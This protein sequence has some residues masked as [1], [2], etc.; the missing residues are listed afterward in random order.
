MNR[1]P[2]NLSLRDFG[3]HQ[4]R[5]PGSEKSVV[6]VHG[7]LS[8]G[9][10]AWGQPSWP[11]LLAK[12]AELQDVGVF[13][14]SYQTT[15]SSRT[16]SIGD[17]VDALREHFNLDG[18]WDQ[19]RLVFVCHSMGGIVARRFIVVNQAK[20]IE[21]NCAI[22]LFLV[23][24]PSLGSSDAN[25]IE[26][27]ALV[28]Q[29]TQALALRFSQS[30]T[31]LN[32]LDRE[33]MAL[34]ESGR[35][36]ITGKELVEDRAVVLKRWLGLRKQVV[37]PFSSGRYF[38]EAF[39]V[40]ASDHISISKPQASDAIQHRIL[41]RFITEFAYPVAD[42]GLVP[43][44][45]HETAQAYNAIGELRGKL[46][47]IVNRRNAL[48]AVHEAVL[49]TLHYVEH[50]RG[51]GSR[52]AQ[53]EERLSRT[54]SEVRH[55]VQPY[56]PDLA[57]L[58]WVKGHGWADE[59]LWKDT[60]FKDIVSQLNEILERLITMVQVKEALLE[61][62]DQITRGNITI[63][64]GLKR[65]LFVSFNSA[66]RQWASWIAWTLEHAGYSVSFQ[67]WDL[68][69][70]LVE[71]MNMALAQSSLTLAVVSDRYFQ[72]GFT[73]TEWAARFA[74]D[75][76]GKVGRVIPVK[77]EP[78]EDEHIF[79][80][81][82]FIDL[83]GCNQVEAR[84]R[85]LEN[86]KPALKSGD[87]SKSMTRPRFPGRPTQPTR[88]LPHPAF[89]AG[90]KDLGLNSHA[91][92]SN[93]VILVHGIRT[94]ALWLHS[95]IKPVLEEH[96]FKVQIINY[97]L[98]D[99]ICFLMPA[100]WIRR[101]AIR[102]SYDQ[103]RLV[104]LEQHPAGQPSIIAHSFGTV[105][106]SDI[107]M[108]E[109]D[110]RADRVIFCGSIV[111]YN[112][113]VEQITARLRSSLLN[114]VGTRDYWPILTESVT[115]GYGS[116]GAYGFR[117][118]AV[119][120]RWHD[121][122]SHST[123]LSKEF[124]REFWV[125]FLQDGTV[126]APERVERT[127]Q[128]ISLLSA[129]KLKYVALVAA[130]GAF[131]LWPRGMDVMGSVYEDVV[132]SIAPRCCMVSGHIHNMA[133]NPIVGAEVIAMS[134]KG[135]ML[136]RDLTDTKGKYHLEVEKGEAIRIFYLVGSAKFAES[137]I[138]PIESDEQRPTIMFNVG[139]VAE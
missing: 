13:V 132:S 124:C 98:L 61:G 106:V 104:L 117:R 69:G 35:P 22:G 8:G 50:R 112:F 44:S 51:G 66:D 129:F 71:H 138:L 65:G 133:G 7:I 82:A 36:A 24:S 114:E 90:E 126:T 78:M 5:K 89:P 63:A 68:R 103:I 6:F 77:I 67:D 27:L 1:S 92:G 72:S 45:E 41:K 37:E 15:L 34:K 55:A 102:K 32:D 60:R 80:S 121:G 53:V 9:E 111:R 26:Q 97:G 131:L 107:L 14:F 79:G 110:F 118:P 93:L 29:H 33:F 52:D 115:W 136:D 127:P 56:D 21:H 28:L 23:A 120:D 137:H 18:L 119:M 19:R 47:G 57:A 99:L 105:I 20:L 113:P 109:F 139:A 84:R 134:A 91:P 38:G 74:H 62:F 3:L 54:W 116:S 59:S 75:A 100:P 83:S 94:R 76:T 16:Y 95:I 25:L 87:R 88:D 49:E 10:D 101:R 128:R 17:V 125:P 122:S 4:I 130:A 96:G 30:N 64:P 86:V 42:K 58:C 46:D 2:D 39:K 70:N 12:E 135:N 73:F 108:R 81:I 85:L 48:A 11:E 31:W 123:F 40:P 43:T